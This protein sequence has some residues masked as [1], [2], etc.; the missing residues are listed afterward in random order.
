MKS[1]RSIVVGTAGHIDHGKTSLVRALTGVDTDR[2][3]EEKRR[4]ITIDLGFASLE[5]DAPDGSSLQVSFVDVPGHALFIRNMLAG[6]GCVPAVMLVIAADE[7]VKPQTR[8]H[9]AICELLGITKGFTV[10]SKVDLVNGLRLEQVRE[11]VHDSLKNSFLGGDKAVIAASARN[12]C[13]FDEIRAE[14][15]EISMQAEGADRTRPMRLPIDRVF[16]KKGFGTVVTG[17]LLSGE[18]QLGQNLMLQPGDRGVRVRGLQTH[19][20]S[21]KVVRAGSRL[22]VNLSGVDAG[23]VSRGQVLVAAGGLTATD[24]IDAR[25]T[26]LEDAPPLKHG[27][28]VH[29]HAFTSEVMARVFVYGG[30]PIKPGATG[31]A[32]LKLSDPIVLLPGDRFVLRH[33]LPAGTV[34]GGRVLDATPLVHE[35]RAVTHKWLE[36]VTQASPALQLESR[37]KRRNSEGIQV[38]ALAREM[39]LS[40]E[41]VRELATDLLGSGRLIVVSGEMMIERNAFYRA[42]DDVLKLLKS[43]EFRGLKRSVLQGQSGLRDD[44]FS[45]VLNSLVLDRKA[46]VSGEVITIAG[47]E[48]AISDKDAQKLHLISAAYQNAGLAAP[49]VKELAEQLRLVEAEIR[50]LITLLIREKTLLRMG[51]DDVFV[52]VDAL[53][54]LAGRMA[55]MRGKVMDV[56]A[57]KS[58]TGLTRKHAIPLLE[59]LD[60]ERITRKQ[61]DVRVVL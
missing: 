23:E 6:A 21:E 32:R 51:S 16:A 47:S 1:A 3:P 15:A 8:E 27:A 44:V 50:R 25:M 26:L 61:G 22:A 40:V 35:G 5:M 12:E 37:V 24:V 38:E 4:G 41:G 13:G 18:V 9:L 31:L 20:A 46:Q 7:G 42:V 39:G 53:R 43:V 19:G 2:L 56:A 11:Q 10:I 55:Q 52:H 45:A 29:L 36:A 28:R 17:T 54:E 57:F 14:L 30:E 58:M 59:L 60:R 34:G 33:P 49:S 48:P